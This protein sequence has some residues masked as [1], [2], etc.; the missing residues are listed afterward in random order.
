[1]G[2][3]FSENLATFFHHLLAVNIAKKNSVTKVIFSLLFLFDV[4]LRPRFFPLSLKS[5]SLAKPCFSVD[6]ADPSFFLFP[7]TAEPI[8]NYG[9]RPYLFKEIF[10]LLYLNIFSVSFI[11]DKICRKVEILFPAS[12]IHN[13]LNN[14][15]KYL[16]ILSHLFSFIIFS[17]STLY[18]FLRP[19]SFSF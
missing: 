5:R 6:F 10:T 16:N 13:F 3:T 15:F 8:S 7:G 18:F 1:M 17:K 2:H 9:F 19:Y 14:H 4:F 11:R 12:H